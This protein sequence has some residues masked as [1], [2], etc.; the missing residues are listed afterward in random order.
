MAERIFILDAGQTRFDAATARR[1]FSLSLA[2]GFAVLAAAALV[3]LHPA[4]SGPLGVGSRHGH[5]VTAELGFAASS[6]RRD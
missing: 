4:R 3:E 2:V 1:Q 5:A 6:P